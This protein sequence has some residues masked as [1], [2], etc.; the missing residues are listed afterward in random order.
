MD[1]GEEGHGEIPPGAGK[2]VHRQGVLELALQ[3]RR[4]ARKGDEA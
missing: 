2:S 4:A 1:Y 3:G